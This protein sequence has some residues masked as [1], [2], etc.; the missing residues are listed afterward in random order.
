MR[1]GTKRTFRDKWRLTSLSNKAIT[2]AT[3]VIAVAGALQFGTAFYQWREMRATGKQTEQMLALV[4]NQIAAANRLADA[5]DTANKNALDSNRPWLGTMGVTVEGTTI[6]PGVMLTAHV[7]VVN[8]GNRPAKLLRFRAQVDVFE[9][10]PRTPAFNMNSTP[11][12]ENGQDIVLPH[13]PIEVSFPFGLSP[14]QYQNVSQRKKRLYVYAVVQYED[15]NAGLRQAVHTTT[16]CY[17]WI[18]NDK[19]TFA[20]CPEYNDAN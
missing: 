18:L 10:F 16:I 13:V 15:V 14:E 1:E 2:L 9:K 19:N 7:P 6:K 11:F 17:F 8:A 4:Q 3:I 12:R 5:A 20:T